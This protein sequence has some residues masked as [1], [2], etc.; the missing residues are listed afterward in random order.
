[1]AAE[2]G[3]ILAQAAPFGGQ[4]ADLYT[5]PVGKQ[6]TAKLVVCN[7]DSVDT[8]RIAISPNG[9]AIQSK[10]YLAFDFPVL[11]ND[12]RIS[13]AFTIEAGDVVRV[14]STNGN[15]SFT[16]TGIEEPL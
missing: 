16:L 8:V 3:K 12:S 5:V 9:E 15:M 6:A 13:T 2:S 7:R 11:A 10:H 4:L 1:M 14:H